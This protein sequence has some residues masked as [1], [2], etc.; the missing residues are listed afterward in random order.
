M[1]LIH[2]TNSVLLKKWILI[3]YNIYKLQVT[4]RF[5]CINYRIKDH[6][7]LF[8][9]INQQSFLLFIKIVKTCFEYVPSFG[10]STIWQKVQFYLIECI[11]Q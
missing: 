4:S 1:I 5:S 7:Q 2:L 10:Y 9:K 8:Q 3:L 6:T 11:A